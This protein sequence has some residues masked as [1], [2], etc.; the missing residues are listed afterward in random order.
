MNGPVPI[1]DFS[2]LLQP[3]LPIRTGEAAWNDPRPARGV[4]VFQEVGVGHLEVQLDRQRVN[5]LGMVEHRLAQERRARAALLEP[6]L[7]RVD[8]VIRG[9][10]AAVDGRL[11]LPLD[12]RPQL[13]LDGLVV[14]VLPA[15]SQLTLELDVAAAVRDPPPG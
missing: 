3:L 12:A 6:I 7:E 2:G 10:I 1:H 14:E 9:Q 4:Q 5:G 13:D 11:V 8:H 15:L